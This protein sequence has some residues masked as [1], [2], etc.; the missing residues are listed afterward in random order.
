M[1]NKNIFFNDEDIEKIEETLSRHPELGSFT[2]TV[3]W[4]IQNYAEPTDTA[5]AF[6]NLQKKLNEMS[7]EQALQTQ[8]LVNIGDTQH[9]EGGASI[10]RQQV[11]LDA[12]EAVNKR[13]DRA[14]TERST[15]STANG[16]QPGF[17]YRSV[18]L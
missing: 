5:A 14:V 6:A 9:I 2:A 1:P 16:D 13:L 15:H 12:V 7:K 3:R 10:E 17:T 4:M 11:Y 18:N 8:L